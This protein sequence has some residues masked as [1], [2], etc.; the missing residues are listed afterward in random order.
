MLQ[1]G[2][3]A[4]EFT[5]PDQDGR[6]VSLSNLLGPGALI[7]YFY[8][9]DFTPGCTREACMMRDLHAELAQS[10]FAVVGVSP[11]KP[12]T[13]RAF[14]D[15]YRLPFTLLSDSDKS[16][17]RMYE[18]V[19]PLGIGIRRATFLIGRGRIIRDAILADFRIGKHEAFI[20]AALALTGR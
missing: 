2:A 13:H 17:A 9:A 18:V 14:R 12:A 6:E 1:E 7:L 4:P 15:K 16:V 5:L 3:R 19:G 8:P 11:Q 10:N 20:R